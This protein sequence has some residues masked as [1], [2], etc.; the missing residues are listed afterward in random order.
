MSV[1][2]LETI[3][4]QTKALTPQEKKILVDYLVNKT[5][6]TDAVDLGL[7][8]EKKDEKRWMRDVWMRSEANRIKYGGWYAALDG[9]KLV[10]TGKNYVEASRQAKKQE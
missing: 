5:E 7:K 8:G 4:E 1:E 10:A 2:I 6:E 9:D 3:K